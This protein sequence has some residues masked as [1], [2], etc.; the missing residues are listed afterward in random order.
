MPQ[1]TVGLRRRPALTRRSLLLLIA[2]VVAIPLY[3]SAAYAATGVEVETMT[4]PTKSGYVLAESAAADGKA[5]KFLGNG[6]ASKH[7]TTSAAASRVVLRARGSQCAGAPVATVTIDGTQRLR[8]AVASTTYSDYAADVALPSGTHTITVAF[9]NDYRSISC[10]RNLYADKITL[11]DEATSTQP[12]PSPTAVPAATDN[13]VR[14]FDSGFEAGLSPWGGVQACPSEGK[15]EVSVVSTLALN[16]AYSMRSS[17]S[18][19]CSF[20]SQRAEVLN[21]GSQYRY[22]EGQELYFADS[23]YFPAN[24]PAT[25]EGHC[26]TMQ[27]HTLQRGEQGASPAFSLSCRDAAAKTNTVMLRTGAP[28]CEWQTPMVRSVWH[29]FVV[30]MKFSTSSSVGSWDMWYGTGVA[31]S[32]TK[33]AANCPVAAL[34]SSTDFGYYKVGLYRGLENTDTATVYHDDTRVGTSFAAVA[35]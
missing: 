7:V 22:T 14:L 1:R 32:Y 9:A 34:M 4:V 16:G 21:A 29:D 17:V 31:P 13:G 10:D 20:G 23:V 5:F 11:L 8:S 25:Q 26:I 35:Q 2:A 12:A 18:G 30:R 6:V 3:A 33:V 19:T 28:G 24:F 15:S 27:I